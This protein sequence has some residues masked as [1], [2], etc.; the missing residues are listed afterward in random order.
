MKENFDCDCSFKDLVYSPSKIMF[1]FKDHVY[2]NSSTRLHYLSNCWVEVD[3]HCETAVQDL[4]KSTE[5]CETKL[6]VVDHTF[7][8]EIET[9]RKYQLQL[10]QNINT[11]AHSL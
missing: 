3:S 11:N 2:S 6:I 10:F 7:R 9:A 4:Q 1:I 5:H 8:L